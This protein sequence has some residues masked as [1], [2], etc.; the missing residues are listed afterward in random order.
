MLSMRRRDP[1]CISHPRTPGEQTSA[2]AGAAAAAG[3]KPVCGTPAAAAVIITCDTRRYS[4]TTARGGALGCSPHGPSSADQRQ[5]KRPR[6][7]GGRGG[8]PE[9]WARG[10]SRGLASMGSCPL[11]LVPSSPLVPPPRVSPPLLCPGRHCP[12]GAALWWRP[13]M[14]RGPPTAPDTPSCACL[15]WLLCLAAASRA[16]GDLSGGV[17]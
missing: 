17:I 7:R 2:G 16:R 5:P 4:S 8:I 1:P 12:R 9:R 3:A 15:W 10:Y 13:S 6:V 11:V 14:R